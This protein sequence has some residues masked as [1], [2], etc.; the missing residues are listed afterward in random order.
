MC[1]WVSKHAVPETWQSGLSTL[2]HLEFG[3]QSLLLLIHSS[4]KRFFFSRAMEGLKKD[5][6]NCSILAASLRF[7]TYFLALCI[8]HHT[9]VRWLVPQRHKKLSPLNSESVSQSC[10]GHAGEL[11]VD[12]LIADWFHTITSFAHCSRPY[13]PQDRANH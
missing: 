10:P 8:P 13:R 12:F 4:L 2:L 9:T 5:P 1:S 7:M 6:A 11:R 3:W